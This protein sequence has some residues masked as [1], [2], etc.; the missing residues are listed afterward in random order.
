MSSVAAHSTF[1]RD[2]PATFP[3]RSMI[4]PYILPC[5]I[6]SACRFIRIWEIKIKN[7][8]YEQI[9]LLYLHQ[10]NSILISG[11]CFYFPAQIWLNPNAQMKNRIVPVNVELKSKSHSQFL[12]FL[13][14][15]I[16]VPGLEIQFSQQKIGNSQFSFYPLGFPDIRTISKTFSEHARPSCRCPIFASQFFPISSSFYLDR[17]S[18][19]CLPCIV[20]AIFIKSISPLK[21]FGRL[22]VF[23]NSVQA[24][25][26]SAKPF[27]RR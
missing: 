17:I 9:L 15:W 23:E 19:R 12:L 5:E 16:P 7:N 10:E 4:R 3:T 21:T 2:T 20:F 26:F 13:G 24:E 14:Q 8:D 11:S 25:K 18:S 1:T 27:H 6:I 22:L